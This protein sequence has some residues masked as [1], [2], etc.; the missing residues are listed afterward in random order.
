MRSKNKKR[1]LARLA[2]RVPGLLC[3]F[4]VALSESKRKYP[5]QEFFSF[6][7]TARRYID[8]TRRDQ[9]RAQRCCS[10]PKGLG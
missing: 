8:L 7:K 1:K 5:V 2:T 4:E 10:G 3:S 9:L 6:A